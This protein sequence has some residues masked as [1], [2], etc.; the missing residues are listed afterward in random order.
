[1]SLLHEDGGSRGTWFYFCH[2]PPNESEGFLL[3]LARLIAL[4]VSDSR[5]LLDL[6]KQGDSKTVTYSEPRPHATR[7]RDEKFLSRTSLNEYFC[8]SFLVDA[9]YN[10][11]RN[12]LLYRR[13]CGAVYV[14]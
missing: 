9:V 5:R 8:V 4:R 13:Y 10:C 12:F 3:S 1:M 7:F 2:R 6:L 14:V 11:V